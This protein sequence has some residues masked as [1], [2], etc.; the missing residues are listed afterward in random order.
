M[1]TDILIV[2]AGLCGL[3]LAR[4]LSAQARDFQLVEA[5]A[6]VG[7]RIATAKTADAGFDLGP[8]WFWSGQPRMA[9]MIAEYGLEAF[10]QYA[11]GAMMIEDAR[12]QV[13]RGHGPAGLQGAFRLAGG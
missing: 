2:G 1:H 5:R 4:A 9:A 6:R 3:A 10:D 7:G 8:A 13:H 12:G 11:P